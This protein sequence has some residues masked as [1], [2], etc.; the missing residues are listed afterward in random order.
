MPKK[1][2]LAGIQTK[3]LKK[4]ILLTEEWAKGKFQ[5]AI[6]KSGCPLDENSIL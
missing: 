2:K 5:D 6:G 1:G 3:S 4:L